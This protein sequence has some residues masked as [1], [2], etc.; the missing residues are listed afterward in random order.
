MS[1][2]YHVTGELTDSQH[3]ILDEPIPLP[4]GKVRVMVEQVP[5]VPKPDLP[6]FERTLRDRQRVRGHVPRT[7]EEIDAY[8][9]AERESWDF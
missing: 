2:V 5:T 9:S 3:V 8:V 1:Q 4:P 7:K 6:T